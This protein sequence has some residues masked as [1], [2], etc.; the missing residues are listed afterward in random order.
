MPSTLLHW[1]MNSQE[2]A[3]EGYKIIVKTDHEHLVLQMTYLL[4]LLPADDYF[5]SRLPIV[6][7]RLAQ[8]GVRLAAILNRLFGNSSQPILSH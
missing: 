4:D 8:G 2:V 6:E 7:A 5:L 1:Y 3:Y